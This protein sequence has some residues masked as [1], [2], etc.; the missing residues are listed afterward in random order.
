MGAYKALKDLH[1]DYQIGSVIGSSAG[2]MI[3]LGIAT[4][5]SFEELFGICNKMQNI[6]LDQ[7]IKTVEELTPD[8]LLKY[9][10]IR[11]KLKRSLHD[12]GLVCN[13]V[14]DLIVDEV[15]TPEVIEKMFEILSADN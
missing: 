10:E 6:P 13:E 15:F 4:G 1:S 9:A 2:G 3:A 8:R 14:F 12:Y 7:T 5:G 11:S